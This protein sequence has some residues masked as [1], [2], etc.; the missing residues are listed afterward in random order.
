M[1]ISKGGIDMA[2]HYII[3]SS[4]YSFGTRIALDI[5]FDDQI[6]GNQMKQRVKEILASIHNECG[7]DVSL[8]THYIITPSEDWASVVEYDAFFE[9]VRVVKSVKK[10]KSLISAD[11]ELS[12]L[13]VAYYVLS[14]EACTHLRLQKLVYLCYAEYL[15]KYHKKLFNDDI[16]AFKY[17]PVTDDIYKEFKG[18]G[19]NTLNDLEKIQ[20][21]LSE[22]PAASRI[23]FSTNGIDKLLT[24]D[25]TIERY[26]SISTNDLVSITHKKGSPWDMTPKTFFN[27]ISD[28]YILKYHCKET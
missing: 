17:G 11:L 24:I 2:K 18:N 3:M 23:I 5:V 21:K 12:S 25:A 26:N 1:K 20:T 4:S 19:S 14:K 28:E 27:K 15:C 6:Q 7:Q 16:H 9:D 8:S 22:L 13:D 10:F